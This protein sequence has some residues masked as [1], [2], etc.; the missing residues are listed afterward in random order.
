MWSCPWLPVQEEAAELAEE[1]GEPWVEV[2]ELEESFESTVEPL[3]AACCTAGLPQ[4]GR[5]DG[6]LPWDPKAPC[7]PPG[8][9]G[10]HPWPCSHPGVM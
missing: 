7:R 10:C 2:G 9:Q 6:P 8:G 3:L 4:V 5:E 1:P